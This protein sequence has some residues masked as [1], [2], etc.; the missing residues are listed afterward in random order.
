MAPEFL[1]GKHVGQVNFNERDGDPGKSIPQRD[2]GMGKC[3]GIDDDELDPF[4]F[5]LMDSVNQVMLGI[6]LIANQAV[7][8]PCGVRNQVLVDVFQGRRP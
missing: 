2:T 6:G 7:T 3:A 4:F 1:P 5:C 8:Q